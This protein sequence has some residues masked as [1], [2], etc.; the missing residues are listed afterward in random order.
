[1][2]FCFVE[3]QI[4]Q[5]LVEIKNLYMFVYFLFLIINHEMMVKFPASVDNN[6][7]LVLAC[8]RLMSTPAL[9]VSRHRSRDSGQPMAGHQ[10]IGRGQSQRNSVFCKTVTSNMAAKQERSSA[11]FE[12]L[13]RELDNHGPEYRAEPQSDWIQASGRKE[14]HGGRVWR[15]LP[16]NSG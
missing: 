5:N 2:S 3:L 16:A 13:S 6:Y 12:Y 7:R 8:L 4:K 1:M 15:G 11:F 10:R 9:S 14:V